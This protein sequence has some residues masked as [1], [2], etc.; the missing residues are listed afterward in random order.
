M[1]KTDLRNIPVYVL[2]AD[3]SPLMPT[4][5]ARARKML[6]AGKAT[7]ANLMP[8]TIRLVK[9]IPDAKTQEVNVGVDTGSK[10]L[11]V[12]ATGNGKVLFAAEVA[13]RTFLKNDKGLESAVA[14]R[15]TLRRARRTRKLR[16]RKPRFDN[17]PRKKCKVCGGNTP[18]S[19]RKGGGRLDLCRRCAAEGHYQFKNVSKS[20][21]WLPPTLLSKTHWHIR[22]V[23]EV[24]KILP[25]S[26]VMVEIADWDIQKLRNPGIA[27]IE[28]QQGDLQDWENRRSYVFA[29]DA[30]MCLYC[31]GKSGDKRLTI[32]HIVPRG[33][34]GTDRVD[35]LAT[36]CYTCNQEKGNLTATEF[37]YPEVQKRVRKSFKHAA[38]VG[39]IKTHLVHKLSQRWPVALTY[40]YLTRIKR[41][42]HLKLP[43]CHAWDAVA[44]SL[45]WDEVAQ[46]VSP[47]YVGKVRARGCRQK[48]NT[49]PV[50]ATHSQKPEYIESKGWFIKRERNT[51]CVAR[52]GTVYRKG[53]R[54]E[55]H[56]GNDNKVRGYISALFSTGRLK[57]K[58]ANGYR[59]VSP[60]KSRLV[61][62]ARPMM[63]RLQ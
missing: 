42:D 39:A 15:A 59:T 6:N 33:S 58:T 62:S 19:D 46:S 35:N 10:T 1:H 24:A 49:Q 48:Y 29:R 34:G 44:A 28:Y 53:D 54:I 11:G 41:R 26:G 21:G 17:R 45:R 43:K 4:S 38:H 18:K 47:I 3:E 40:G 63:F 25:V 13:L 8:F 30:W 32:D 5:P 14:E 27:G 57:I 37:G 7:V 20:P 55:A 2:N 51:E 12:A 61:Q 56:V 50:K 9:F 60:N 31:K 22:A 52:D 23:E 16:Y 36:S